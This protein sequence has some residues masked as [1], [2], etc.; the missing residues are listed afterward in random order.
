[1]AINDIE[2]D[3]KSTARKLHLQFGHPT[4]ETLIQLLKQAK[5]HTKSL[6]KEVHIISNN[7][8]ICLRNK[9]SNPRPVVCLPLARR[10]N[11]LIGMD[12]K[13]WNKS[14]YF[15]VMVDIATRFCQ[16]RVV[17]DKMPKTII[18]AIFV[19]WITTFGAPRN[20]SPTMVE[21]L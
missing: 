6:S 18:K 9:K 12:L 20:F 7:C 5:L 17:P 10:F 21:S 15:L 11:E 3:D 13:Y 14:T 2:G 8:I 19:S 16:A 4:P 1:M